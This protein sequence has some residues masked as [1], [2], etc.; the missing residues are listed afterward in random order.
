MVDELLTSPD[1]AGLV[2]AQAAQPWPST[3]PTHEQERNEPVRNDDSPEE[4]VSA[5]TEESQEVGQVQNDDLPGNGHA[6]P[7]SLFPLHPNSPT[8]PI[9]RAAASYC[10][11]RGFPM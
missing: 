8:R 1:L 5:P 3:S 10:C 9:T 11:L 6:K 2:Q 7:R 4:E